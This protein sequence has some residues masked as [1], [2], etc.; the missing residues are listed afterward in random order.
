MKINKLWFLTLLWVSIL[1]VGCNPANNTAINRFYHSTTAQYNG[2]F[3]ANLLLDDAL[4]SYRDNLRE[5]YYSLL[6]IQV[7]PT[8]EDVQTLYPAIDTA[9]AKCSKVI[10][11]HSM[12][13]ASAKAAKKKEENN[14]FIDENWITIGKAS[15][16]RRDYS[17]ALK[18]FQFI[19]KFYVNDPSNY[20]GEL[21]M[22]KTALA[23]KKVTEAGFHL[24][25]IK[26]AIEDQREISA[27]D[28]LK[29]KFAKKKKKGENEPARVPRDLYPL[30]Y[31]TRAEYH[32]AKNEEDLLIENLELALE[33]IKKKKD[34]A[35]I[36]FILG[37]LQEAKGNRTN[38]QDYYSKVLKCNAPYD[39]AFSARLKRAFLGAN[40]KLIKD[41]NKM[42]KDAKNAEYR[43]QIYYALAQIELEKNNKPETFR[44]LTAS[45]F[46]ST[47][48]ARQ[49]AMAYEQMGNIRFK[50][51]NYVT[52]QKYY[53]SCAQFMPDTY[54]NAEGIRNKALKLNDLVVAVESA[55][56]EDSLLRISGMNESERESYVENVIEILKER[57][58]LRKK[59]EAEKLA[60][61]AK[62]ES[63][64][65][66]TQGGSK[67]YFRN[68]KT[69][70]EGY[71]DFK[72]QWGTREDEDN[73]RRS[74]KVVAANNINTSDSTSSNETA[75]TVSAAPKA[76]S[77]TV[78]L[79]MKDVPLTD[80]AIALSQE[81]LCK[82]LYDAGIIYK[83]QLNEPGIA[84][85]QFNS[86]LEKSWESDYKPM[87][88]FELYRINE[89]SNPSVAS[90]NKSF[91]MNNYPNSDYA[92]YLRDPDFFI[93]K[94]EMD[95]FAEKE[96]VQ[97][98]DRYNA[99]LYY[100]VLT[101]AE[102]IITTEPN[103]VFR[104][105]YMLLKAMC[106]GRLNA[107][108]TTMKPTLELIVA[109]YPETPEAQRAKEML[110]IM[111]NGYSSFEK[112]DF[113]NKSIYK[114]NDKAKMY[115]IVFLP[116]NENSSTAK[117]KISDFSREFF[118]RDRLRVSSKIYGSTQS[119]VMIEEFETDLKAKEY[120]RV[121]QATRKHLFELQNA[122]IIAITQENLRILFE[123]QKLKEYEDFFL[124]FY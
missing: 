87:A 117:S 40:E 118:S 107:D 57:E 120:I 119:I 50:E 90:V 122:K 37:Q 111:E 124:E 54:P 45:A 44:Y 102:K 101:K 114:Y 29:A 104:S 77:L 49:K 33:V 62:N 97:S 98:L 19:K 100:P 78:E 26:Q 35:R 8:E 69:R 2:Y 112:D 115:V 27:L 56:R 53:D 116:E 28:R 22:A 12:P 3:N 32:Q 75:N 48:N 11:E 93:K 72:R 4:K 30:Y 7:Y 65:N 39:M 55:Q 43:D 42:L 84:S 18:N 20:I 15:Y 109:E 59:K 81:R 80:S 38:A 34:K 10:Q 106:Q 108:K 92:N 6:P 16:L 41:L 14:N 60:E 79:L 73:W 25:A 99:G 70:A 52:A 85:K 17:A 95:A 68:A 9:I 58:R 88:A 76:D 110:S 23:E 46:Y 94:K 51:K 63:G 83:D 103:N 74:E 1:F 113:S 21:W 66:Q 64:F 123:T 47:S 82:S 24:D 36:Y 91:L 86:V 71:D 61:L 13:G 5:D 31:L 121:Y 89:K 105:K 96:Y 67:W